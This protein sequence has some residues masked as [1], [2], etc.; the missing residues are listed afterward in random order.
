MA[1]KFVQYFA[2]KYRTADASEVQEQS[3]WAQNDSSEPSYIK[4]KPGNFTGATSQDNGAAGFVP[5]PTTSDTT[6]FLCGNGAW[7]TA[8]GAVDSV[9]GQT[10]VVVLDAQAVGALPDDTPIPTVNVDDVEVNGVSV[11]DANKVANI[12]SY[13]E[14]TKAQYEA[15]PASKNSDNVLYA[16]KDENGGGGG[17]G[18]G[19]ASQLNDLSD[20]DIQNVADGQILIYSQLLS[21]FINKDFK[22]ENSI[23]T[24][25]E[26]TTGRRL[27][28]FFVGASGG[29]TT[30]FPVF[31]Y[32]DYM[33]LTGIVLHRRGIHAISF[34]AE[35]GGVNPVSLNQKI[36]G[37]INFS[38]TYSN[39][40][41]IFNV[42][43]Y[44]QAFF[45]GWTDMNYIGN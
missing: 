1:W 41:I 10:G 38:F 12:V 25:Q 42:G 39:N 37:D 2:G 43:A 17:G 16:I 27:I 22:T 18:G 23:W 21:A 19:G 6:K 15:L 33:N 36:V 30:N 20:V 31:Q 5:A 7:E 44:D 11:V 29:S 45:I 13:K 14:V 3:D 32:T 35:G 28:S 40:Q 26:K 8:G 24:P 34:A 9:N 4:N